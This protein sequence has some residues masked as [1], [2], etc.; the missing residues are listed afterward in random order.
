MA[1][2]SPEDVWSMISSLVP[3]VFAFLAQSESPT[4]DVEAQALLR[5]TIGTCLIVGARVVADM[6]LGDQNLPEGG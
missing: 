4:A 3:S 2:L 1:D 6:P 5:R